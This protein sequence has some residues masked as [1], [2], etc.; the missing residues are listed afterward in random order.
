MTTKQAI[1]LTL[2]EDILKRVEKEAKQQD[3]S[4]SF[5]INQYLIKVYGDKDEKK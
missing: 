1:S 3:R 4:S 5:I 2:D